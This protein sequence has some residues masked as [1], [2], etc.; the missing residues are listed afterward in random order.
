[1]KTCPKCNTPRTGADNFCLNCGSKFENENHDSPRKDPQEPA[2]PNHVRKKRLFGVIAGALLLMVI[3]GTHFYL[4]SKYD[5]SKKLIEMNQAFVQNEPSEFLSFFT[6][7]KKV[8]AD[9]KSFISFVEKEDWEDIRDQ[10][11]IE[12][13]NLNNEGFSDVILDSDGNKL[14]SVVSKPILL[15][16][17]KETSFLVHPINVQAELPFDKT[18]LAI[19]GKTIVGN[20]GEIVSLG[21][22]LPG[23]YDWKASVKS[24]YSL[25]ENNGAT[26]IIG[27]GSNKFTFTPSLEAGLITVTSDVENAVLW[28]DGKSTGKTLKEMN[29]FGPFPFDGTVKITA[30]GKDENN[31]I[32]KGETVTVST[33]NIHIPFAH[34]QEKN[35]TAQKEKEE[36]AQLQQLVSEHE[37]W[38]NELI[39]S[40][41]YEFEYALNNGDFSYISSFFPIGSPIQAEYMAKMDE[42][43]NTTDY[44][45]YDFQ[46]TTVTDIQAIS[47]KNFQVNT[48]EVFYYSLN[49]DD[50][51][52]QK[53]KVYTVQVDPE[54]SGYYITDI[55]ELSS[56]ITDF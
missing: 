56:D 17:Y 9:E 5:A 13:E 15:G 49:G 38:I 22:F 30:E 23:I 24:E 40:F 21:E 10:L 47:Q 44:Y 45:E 35:A 43:L 1:M 31:S 54:G 28:V 36:S 20:E 26:E 3:A 12:V 18:T 39:Q 51:I 48:G 52:Y 33:A 25:V 11:K 8:I 2:V 14:L 34:I 46:S 32:V 41:R 19:D 50:M 4:Q 7:N 16:L 53:T 6:T 29:N 42:H 55:K 37:T 27:D